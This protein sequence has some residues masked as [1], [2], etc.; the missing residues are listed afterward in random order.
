MSVRDLIQFARANTR[1]RVLIGPD[2]P[3]LQ[4]PWWERGLRLQAKVL[5]AAK[6]TKL[7]EKIDH[8]K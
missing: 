4:H 7:Q 2:G 5:A 3:Y 8:A 1:T 6:P